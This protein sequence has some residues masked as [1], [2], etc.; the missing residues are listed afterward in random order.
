VSSV[1]FTVN[2]AGASRS[3]SRSNFTRRARCGEHIDFRALVQTRFTAVAPSAA[4]LKEGDI[5]AKSVL[6]IPRIS[7]EFFRPISWDVRAE[8]SNHSSVSPCTPNVKLDHAV[9][10]Q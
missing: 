5:G 2:A 10:R 1:V 9:C 6:Q 4:S 3:S 8:L 7:K